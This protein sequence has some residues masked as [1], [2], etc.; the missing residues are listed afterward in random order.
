MRVRGRERRER[1]RGERDMKRARV[2]DVDELLVCVIPIVHFLTK[3]AVLIK[4]I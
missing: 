3:C 2:I 4:F 1:E